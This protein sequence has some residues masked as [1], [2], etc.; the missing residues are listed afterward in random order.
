MLPSKNYLQ[1]L[2]INQIIN[3]AEFI[4]LEN[5]KHHANETLPSNHKEDIDAIYYEELNYFND[6][7]IFV[8]KDMLGTINGAIRVLQWNFKDTLP[9]QKIFGIHPLMAVKNDRVN[10]IFHIGRFAINKSIGD[11]NLFKKLM[12]CA[13]KPVCEHKDNVAFA[14]CDSK[15]LRVLRLLGIKATIIGKPIHYLGSE[16]IPVALSYDGLINF[17]NKNKSLVTVETNYNNT[18]SLPKSVVFNTL[19]TNYPLV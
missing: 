1:K 9:L 15:L 18:E 4:V 2:E 8:S 16:T 11:I 13:I 3:L 5:Y 14:E 10:N 17:Y 6:S 19:N 12:V 7:Q